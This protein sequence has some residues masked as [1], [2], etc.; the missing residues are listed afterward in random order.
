MK[1][2]LTLSILLLCFFAVSG[3]KVGLVFSGGGAKGLAH[4]GVL[5]ALEENNIPIDYIVGTSMGGIVG[6]MYASGYTPAEI[7]TIALSEDFQNWVSGYFESEYRYFYNKKPE[8]PSFITAKLQIDTGFNIKLRSNLINDVPL[9]FALLELY[10]QASATA[11][12]DFNK[13]F[14]PF[15]C[16]VADVFTQQMIPVSSGNLSEAI[17]GTFTVP[18]VYRPIKVN[19]KYV[20]DGGIYNN[21]PVDVMKKDFKPDYIIGTNVSSKTYNNYPKDNDEKLMNRFL[22]YMFLSKTDSTSIGEKGAYIQ[23]DLSEYSTT[24]FTPVAELIKKGYEAALADIPRI[25][26]ALGRSNTAEELKKRREDFKGGLSLLEF[27][28]IT[29]SG[30]NSKQKTYVERIIHNNIEEG[31]NLSEIKKG[32]YKLVADQNFETV[33]PKIVYD[34]VSDVNSFEVAVQPEKNFK[35][36]FGGVISTRPISNA[37]VGLQYNYLRKKSYTFSANFYAG[38]FYESAQT[39]ARVDMPSKLPMYLEAEFTYNH[40]NYFNKSQIFI[41]NVKPAFIEQSDR[42]IVLKLGIPFTKNGK[43]EAQTGFIN[44]DDQYSPNQVFRFGDLMDFNSYNGLMASIN[45]SKNLLTRRQYAKSGSS[46]KVGLSAYTGTESYTPGNIFRDESTFNE[47]KAS[48]TNRHWFKAIINREKYFVL[49]KKY[50][51]GYLIEAVVSNRPD[52]STYKATILSAPAFNPLQDSKSL[53]LENFRANNY[54]AFGLKNVFQVYKNLDFRAEGYI[55]QPVKEFK[56]N[57]LQSVGYGEL[58]ADSHYALTAGF[59]YNTLAGPI[60]LSL[61]HYDDDQKR[62]GLMFHIGFLIYNKRSFE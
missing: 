54:G 48:E 61:N 3:Q 25:K 29:A 60:S 20:F 24:N 32:Y 57:K 55:F 39:T 1:R 46:F 59:V 23:P 56:L 18:L 37:F 50:S 41:E 17:R 45:Y 34:K 30:I 43:L 21:F 28:K 16:I 9:N 31:S 5:K 11:K 6:G 35:I 8:N 52:F 62:F 10:G 2:T 7:E 4:I 26:K 33:Y 14:V 27:N 36:D 19:D 13:L 58:F 12:N 53:Y 51:L 40:W 47:I 49:S 44:F 15:R 38:G 42:R 22:V